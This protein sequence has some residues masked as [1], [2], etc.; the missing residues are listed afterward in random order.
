MNLTTHF[1]QSM[2]N[3]FS[4]KLRTFLSILGVLVGT[5]S[6]VAVV[7]T[8]ELGTAHALA[9]FKQL[10]TNLLSVSLESPSNSSSSQTEEKSLNITQLMQVSQ[11]IPSIQSTAPYASVYVN[12][13]YQGKSLNAQI[14]GATQTLKKIN[15]IQLSSGRFI[16]PLDRQQLYA[17]IGSQVAI[18]LRKQGVF[19]PINQQIKLGS[20]IFTIIGVMKPLPENFFLLV[21]LNNSVVTPLHQALQ[22][23]KDTMINN[24]IYTLKKHPDINQLQGKIKQ[25]VQL[26]SPNMQTFFTSPEQIIAS[27]SKQR[28]TLT[29]LLACIGAISLLV[30]GIGVM[31]IMLVSVT[32]RRQ[33]IGIRL[34]IGALRKD[35]K[36]MFL[37]ESTTLTVFG[38]LLGIIIGTLISW[39]ITLFTHWQFELYFWPPVAGF[40]V[41]V[42]VGVFFGLYPA[43]KAAK[44]DP[45]ET[46]RS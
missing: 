19:N 6:V 33:E 45:I 16:S 35:I 8:G 25:L 44:L 37:L 5:A 18:N 1:S 39:V 40:L 20:Y 17:V 15:K 21:D 42:F 11:R 41:S 30:G 34:A 27:M 31:N 36:R 24:V 22:L 9:Q 12:A 14:I 32:E 26:Y 23:S 4:A 10:G 29:W 2:R 28:E 38:G 43:M 13:S 46:L 7:T 3:L